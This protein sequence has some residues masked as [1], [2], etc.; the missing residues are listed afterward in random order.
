MYCGSPWVDGPNHISVASVNLD[1]LGA[2]GWGLRTQALY[3]KG[4]EKRPV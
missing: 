4:C 2:C 1:L 3:S